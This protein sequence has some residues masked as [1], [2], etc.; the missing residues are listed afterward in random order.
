M[1][2]TVKALAAA[3]ALTA[4]AGAN[5]A[6]IPAA[7]GTGS[8]VLLLAWDNVAEVGYVRDLGVTYSS[9]FNQS[10]GS[11][12]AFAGTAAE[13]ATDALFGTT[14]GASTPSN[15]VWGV[16][17]IDASGLTNNSTGAIV[18]RPVG[19]PGSLA[20][21]GIATY[22]NAQNALVGSL[23]NSATSYAVSGLLNANNPNGGVSSSILAGSFGA[24]GDI[25]NTTLFVRSS[26][27]ATTPTSLF[28]FE[29]L[30][31]GT[32][33]Y[34]TTASGACGPDVA[35]IPVPAAVWL[36]GSA[37]AGMAGVARRRV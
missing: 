12:T 26:S 7:T 16:T 4:S 13:Y 2:F 34:G 10:N 9:F 28:Q 31:N 29:L 8:T 6:Y 5:A 15:I 30:A 37:L 35:P 22:G 32:L 18:T 11:L 14:F 36:L 17:A 3:I 24:L 33:C 20:V 23:L 27:S 19:S 25:L 1:N 21:G